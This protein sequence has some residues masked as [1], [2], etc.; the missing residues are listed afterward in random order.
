MIPSNVSHTV[1]QIKTN[2]GT[3]TC[4]SIAMG[5]E[6]GVSCTFLVTAKHI[7]DGID[8]KDVEIRR[9]D[10]WMPNSILKVFEIP[11]TDLACFIAEMMPTNY[12]LHNANI[13]YGEDLYFLGFPFGFTHI[14]K[15]EGVMPFVKKCIV[16]SV[17]ELNYV[18]LDGINNKGFSGGPVVRVKWDEDGKGSL[19]CVAVVSGYFNDNTGVIDEISGATIG[20]TAANSGLIIAYPTYFLEDFSAKLQKHIA[21][22]KVPTEFSYPCS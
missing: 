1:F 22:K 15:D 3:A 18:V 14:H 2:R 8:L 7:L 10:G 19:E 11:N 16:S 5:Q 20:I 21:D 4:F 17:G 13:T 6:I 9:V 12:L